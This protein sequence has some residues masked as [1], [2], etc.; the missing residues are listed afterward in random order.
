MIEGSRE[1]WGVRSEFA[2]ATWK[3]SKSREST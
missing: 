3:I 2:T 1:R